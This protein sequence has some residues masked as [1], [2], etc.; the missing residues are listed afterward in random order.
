MSAKS[1]QT[2]LRDTL[3]KL[4]VSIRVAREWKQVADNRLMFLHQID[5]EVGKHVDAMCKVGTIFGVD[6]SH[7]GMP[8]AQGSCLPGAETTA[9]ILEKL[10]A[11]AAFTANLTREAS[12]L[13]ATLDDTLALAI[14]SSAIGPPL[15]DLGVQSLPIRGVQT[16]LPLEEVF[17]EIEDAEVLPDAPAE[18]SSSIANAG[19]ES[20]SVALVVKRKGIFDI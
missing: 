9:I 13:Q 18:L 8:N 17:G 10:L 7:P 20:T 16:S 19:D 4:T 3:D 5:T 2:K 14:E 15:H 11:M 6:P 1:Y 12:S